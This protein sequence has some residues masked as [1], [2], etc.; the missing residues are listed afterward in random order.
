MDASRFGQ[1]ET[2]QLLLNAGADHNAR[3]TN[4]QTA[5]TW[6]SGNGHTEIVRML[7][8]AG[9]YP[10]SAIPA[11]AAGS[12][13]QCA[14]TASLILLDNGAHISSCSW[15]TGERKVMERQPRQCFSGEQHFRMISHHASFERSSR[16]CSEF[17]FGA[18]K[19]SYFS[20]S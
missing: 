3:I 18:T 12:F 9:A 16:N 14:S 5:M 11:A 19:Q 4:G 13:S 1:G 20:R 17:T 2:V 7:L 6:A 10:G 8:E 15:A